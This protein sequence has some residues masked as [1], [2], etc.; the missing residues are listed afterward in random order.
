MEKKLDIND[1]KNN[2]KCKMYCND[3]Y[4]I[5]SLIISCHGFGG[6]KK[7][8][9]T[10]KIAESFLKKYDDVAV[11]AFD[12]PCHGEDIKQKLKLDDCMEY[13]DSVINYAKEEIKAENL[14][15]QATSFGGY[16]SLKYI[17]EK[18]NPFKKIAYRCPAINM[19]DLLT[20]KVLSEDD[21]YLIAK[22]KTVQ[23]G[24]NRKI[25]VDKELL[26]ELYKN[27]VRK[28]DFVDES[29]KI[30]IT[31]GTNDELVPYDEVRDFADNNIIEFRTVEGADHLFSNPAK[32][33]KYIDYVEELYGEE[34]D[35]N[36]TK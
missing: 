19:Y 25:K 24:F 21:L 3:P 14:F 20:K 28:L 4:N 34:L 36:M 13:F 22:G 26:E 8:A 11:L 33:R 7:N 23:V 6:N 12:W 35:K 16:L 27:D 9:A 15:L 30:L 32:M 5:N 17:N 29:E 1:Y 18:N 31:Q 10:K 2:I